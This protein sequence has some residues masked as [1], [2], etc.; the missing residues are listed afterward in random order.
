MKKQSIW[1]IW[2]KDFKSKIGKDYILIDIRTN[3]EIK[4]WYIKWM[5]LNLDYYNPNYAK[6]L[7]KLDRNKKYLIYCHSWSRTGM[8]LRFMEQ[9]WFKE[10]YHLSWWIISWVNDWEELLKNN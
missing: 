1:A 9:I 10:V 7:D 5:D 8:T 4:E 3:P 2:V 6:E